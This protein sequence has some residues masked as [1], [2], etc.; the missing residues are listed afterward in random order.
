[1]IVRNRIHRTLYRIHRI[2]ARTMRDIPGIV[3]DSLYHDD[4]E[5]YLLVM[6]V[7]FRVE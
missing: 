6:Y 4:D 7:I 1:V 5:Q 3:L 2:S